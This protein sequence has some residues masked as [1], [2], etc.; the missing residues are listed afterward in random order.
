MTR[1]RMMRSRLAAVILLCMALGGAVDARQRPDNA[2]LRDLLRER[3]DL[4]SL[5]DGVGLVPRARDAG[6]RII[7][8]RN[9]AVSVDGQALTGGELR[10][11]LGAD[12]NLILRVTY[13]DAADQRQL[14]ASAQAD[15]P[16]VPDLPGAGPPPAPGP[17]DVP[18]STRRGGDMVRIGDNVTVSRNEV[19]DGDVVVVFGNATIDGEVNGELTVVM[20]NADLGADAVVRDDVTVVGGTLNRAPGAVI[21]GRVENVAVGRGPWR[22]A[23]FPGML[24]ETIFGRVGSL[25]GTLFRV[26]FVTL[27]ALVVV[28]FGRPWIER[29]ADRAS[30][31]PLR[32]GLTGFLAQ[33]LF[34]PV[35]LMT[36]VVLAISIVGIPLLLLLPFAI[37]LVLIVLLVGFTGV[38]Y[39]VGRLLNGQFGWTERGPYATV[40]LG[41]M[42][43]AL[44]T[45]LARSA[46]VIGGSFLTFPLSA[47]GYM[48]EYAAWTLGFGAAILVWW[49]GRRLGGG[50]AV[51]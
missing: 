9:G 21:E 40:L 20:G 15:A 2:D 1:E 10:T 3:Y 34:F 11:R 33:L 46:A 24:R 6:I 27:L 31:D 49:R 16:R 30:S 42:T 41:V 14:A 4:L 38:A 37:V 48:V 43:I 17:P 12:A 25:A 7:E 51:P 47:A 29:I 8:V 32:A 13:L 44:V 26:A 5:Q 39:H 45:V 19:I 36:I 50:V 22:G 28:A 23:N 35:L 18:R